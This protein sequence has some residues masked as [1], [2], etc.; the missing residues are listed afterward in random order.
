M[1]NSTLTAATVVVLA[2]HLL[3][4]VLALTRW[5][6]G[7]PIEAINL[8]V[9]VG[10]LVYQALHPLLFRP[11]LD[12]QIVALLCFALVSAAAA[13]AAWWH[14]PFAIW[15]CWIAFVLQLLASVA[16]VVFAMTFRI[17]RLF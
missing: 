10:I 3:A 9:A 17:T 8:A 5:K 14:V 11:P 4:L 7:G 6:G 13:T 12:E 2:A 16:A 1:S 15:L